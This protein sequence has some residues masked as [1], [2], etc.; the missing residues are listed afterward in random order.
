MP[1]KKIAVSRKHAAIEEE[2]FP[3]AADH[4]APTY[5]FKKEKRAWS[6]STTSSAGCSEF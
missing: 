6:L 4:S 2:I 1:T 5:N 3:I